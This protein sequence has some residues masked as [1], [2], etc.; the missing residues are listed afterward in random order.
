MIELRDLSFAYGRSTAP[1]LH[2]ISFCLENGHVGAILGKN[3]AGKSTLLKCIDRI[4]RPQSGSVLVDGKDV[5]SLSGP[6]MARQVAYVAQSARSSDLSVFDTVL[7][8]RRP[9]IRWDV[10]AADREI[11]MALLAQL[12]LEPLMLRQLSQLSGGEAQKVLLARALAQQPRLL[13]LDEPTS[14]LDPRN[15]HEVMQLVQKI[16]RDQ[17][18]CV[19]CVLHDLNLAVRYCDRFLLLKDHSVFDSGGPECLDPSRIEA[20]YDMHVHTIDYMGIP[21]I[22]PFPDVKIS[23]EGEK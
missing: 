18:I 16:A 15:Q 5:L 2:N 6:E 14:N 1:V 3:G 10:T 19:I 22:V 11:V 17:N 9:Y 23:H 7:L 21:V 8:G 13:L 20:V 12:N 4:L